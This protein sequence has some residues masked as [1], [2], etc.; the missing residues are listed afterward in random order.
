[1]VDQH[2]RDVVAN[3]VDAVAL[4]ALQAF[5]RFLAMQERLFAGRADQHVEQILRN[6]AAILTFFEF[7]RGRETL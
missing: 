3:R 5:C 2:D 1:M 7:D 4:S 6:H